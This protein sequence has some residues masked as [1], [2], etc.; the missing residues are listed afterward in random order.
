MVVV[1]VTTLTF[2]QS[3]GGLA[4]AVAWSQQSLQPHLS[5]ADFH[6]P[7]NLTDERQKLF[8]WPDL[9]YR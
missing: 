8:T 9:S 3:L 7:L 2:T 4:S 1:R 6:P 5:H